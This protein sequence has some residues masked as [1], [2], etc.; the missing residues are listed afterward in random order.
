MAKSTSNRIIATP[1]PYA[2][3]H[4]IYVQEVGTLQSLEPHISQRQNLNSY[5]FFIVLDGSGYV[6]YEGSRLTIK[7][8]DCVWLDC[9]KSYSHESSAKEP[10]SLMWVHFYGKEVP[11]FYANFLKQSHSF[12]FQPENTIAFTDI[13]QHIFKLHASKTSMT[14]LFAN[15][16]LTDLVTLCFSEVMQLNSVVP[17]I[18]EKLKQV[19]DYLEDNY[20]KKINLED[21]SSRF[22]I[23]KFHLSREYKKVY[24]VTIGNDLTAKRISHAKSMLRFSDSSI[25]SIAYE[26][27]FQNAGYFIKVFK[28]YENMTPAEYRKKW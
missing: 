5:L 25:E 19:N 27:G 21:L 8:G 26:C 17:S 4:Y 12:I 9:T 2:R 23:S 18:P 10:W 15:R 1:S 20:A 13:I 24:G 14:E 22:Y 7:T 28:K 11:Y 6:S 16:C 3:E